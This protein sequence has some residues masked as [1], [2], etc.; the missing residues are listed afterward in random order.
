[1]ARNDSKQVLVGARCGSI[2]AGSIAFVTTGTTLA[3]PTPL[4]FVYAAI[5]H[6]VTGAL[7]C[8]APAG[9]VSGGSVT[10]TRSSGT[11]SAD[12]MHYI[13]VGY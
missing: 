10:F 6:S 7:V 1:M 4:S 12:V 5:G 3:V 2:D 8:T 13:M 11:A 9:V